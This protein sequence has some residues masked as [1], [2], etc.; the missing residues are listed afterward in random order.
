MTETLDELT[1]PLWCEHPDIC[2]GEHWRGGEQVA[3]T[4]TRG[5]VPQDDGVLFGAAAVTI[6]EDEDE[7]VEPY[8]ELNTVKPGGQYIDLCFRPSE[9][10]RLAAALTAA[11]DLLDP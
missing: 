10:K 3:A 7:D 2:R 1:H 8:I 5:A 4:A 6:R 11:A 9:A